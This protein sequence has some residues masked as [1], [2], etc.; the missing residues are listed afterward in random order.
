MYGVVNE[1]GGTGGRARLPNIEVC[2]KTG[3][4]PVGLQRIYEGRRRQ[5]RQET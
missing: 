1:G 4:R 3:I 2:G 5:P